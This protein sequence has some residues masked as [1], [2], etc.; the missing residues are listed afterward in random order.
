MTLSPLEA[1][2]AEIHEMNKELAKAQEQ[3]NPN[4]VLMLLQR[5]LGD[6]FWILFLWCLICFCIGFYRG[7]FRFKYEAPQSNVRK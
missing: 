2:V 1:W 4:G 3:D 6:N 5:V 7:F